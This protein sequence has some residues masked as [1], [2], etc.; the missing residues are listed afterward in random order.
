MPAIPPVATCRARDISASWSRDVTDA[1]VGTL[2][3]KSAH[4]AEVTMVDHDGPAGKAG[5]RAH[6]VILSVNGMQ[7]D[8]EDGLHRILR[9]LQPGRAV[10][11]NVCRG[12]TDQTVNAT[13]ANRTELEKQA[14]EQHWVVPEPAA[15]LPVTA[16][17]RNLRAAAL[18]TALSPATCSR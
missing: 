13:M 15:D 14:W 18:D 6:D 8:D 11:L 10:S 2:H 4:G 9:D 3:L 5:L 17:P 12:G 16:A 7:V 1:E